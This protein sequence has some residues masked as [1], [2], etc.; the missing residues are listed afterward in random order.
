MNT[1]FQFKQF[2]IHQEK[3]AMKVC[4]DACLFGA[5]VATKLEDNKIITENILDIGCGTGL[6]TLMIA[7]KSSAQIDAIEIDKQAFE[8]AGE[9]INLSDWKER[10]S[11]HYDSITK[12][13]SSKKFG[14]IICNPPFYESQLKSNND[15]RNKAMHAI[16]L[17]YVEL[18][19]A[20]KNNLAK[21][22]FAA[23]LLP[24]SSVKKIEEILLTHQLFII[25][26]TKV[27]HSPLHPF[28]RSMLLISEVEKE[29]LEY[30]LCIK[31]TDKEYSK[32]FT[33]LLKDY[34][35]NF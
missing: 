29:Q 18:V 12:L 17:S 22:G 25:E 14:L 3:S 9:N 10:I 13:R 35:L 34:Y 15:E 32:E 23:I 19:I 28:F 33:E 11:I 2:T 16:T 8:Q 30:S 7:Q 24:F 31:N 6:L 1:W 21:N 27:A 26:K 5:W 20:I 4:T